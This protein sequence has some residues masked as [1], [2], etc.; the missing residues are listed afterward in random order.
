[1]TITLD[2]KRADRVPTV[3]IQE[4]L[5]RKGYTPGP[6]DGR[7]GVQTL[8]AVVQFSSDTGTP[9]PGGVVDQT[10][11]DQIV[12]VTPPVPAPAPT[13]KTAPVS[14]PKAKKPTAP[15]SAKAGKKGTAK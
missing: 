8:R 14:K 11:Y 9:N 2:Y 10:L 7:F 12:A 4:A 1:M 6:V 13:G 3:H 15:P 5:T